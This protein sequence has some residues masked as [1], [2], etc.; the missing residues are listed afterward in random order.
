MM[1]INTN[2][3]KSSLGLCWIIGLNIQYFLAN[4]TQNY[5]NIKLLFY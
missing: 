2:H 3:K 5:I 1:L 4:T